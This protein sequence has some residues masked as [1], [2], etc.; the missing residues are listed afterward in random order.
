MSDEPQTLSSQ[1]K[2]ASESLGQLNLLTERQDSPSYQKKLVEILGLLIRIKQQVRY[3]GLFSDNESIDDL[4]TKDIKFLGVDFYL[5]ELIGKKLD[6]VDGKVDFKS[7]LRNLSKAKEA[8]VDYLMGLKDYGLLNDNQVMRMGLFKEQFE[9]ELQELRPSDPGARR[10]EKI[11]NFRME[12][13]LNERLEYF[14][15]A[16]PKYFKDDDLES[17]GIDEESLREIY[18]AKLK[19]LSLK[20]FTQLEMLDMEMQVV[21]NRPQ[22]EEI[23]APSEPK[24]KS[25][26]A[27]NDYGYTDKLEFKDKKKGLLSKDGKVLQPFTIVGSRE[28]AKRKVFGYGQY[29]PTMSVE[30]YIDEEIK[31]GG[32]KTE[33][34]TGEEKENEDLNSSEDEDYDDVKIY[35][36]RSWDEF[37]DDH[38]RGEGNMK[39]KG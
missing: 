7:K 39:D 17:S 13:T 3:A 9:P 5:G 31:R 10:E 35:D 1:L 26:T 32:I 12:K 36:K 28:E 23:V 15:K 20:A 16:Y 14:E 33:K 37:K 11:N 4:N 22:I 8:L 2:K 18:T 30:E 19:L 29:L 27:D 38:R 24:N 6:M 34:I 25:L 21:K